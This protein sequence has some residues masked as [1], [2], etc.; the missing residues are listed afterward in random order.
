MANSYAT[1]GYDSAS[2]EDKGKAFDASHSNPGQYAADNFGQDSDTM[3][4]SKLDNPG[5]GRPSGGQHRR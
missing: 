4:L 3:L 2:P 1:D 5:N